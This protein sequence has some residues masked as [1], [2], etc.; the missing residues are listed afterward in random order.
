MRLTKKREEQT[1]NNL[2]C[3]F[4]CLFL[5]GLEVRNQVSA[6]LR[7]L[8]PGEAH[9]GA[10]HEL[11]GVLQIHV[12]NLRGPDG[13]AVDVGLRVRVALD[14]AGEAAD[15]AVQ[16][17]ADAVLAALLVG[18]A[19][20]RTTLEDRLAALHVTGGQGLAFLLRGHLRTK[21]KFFFCVGLFLLYC[22][23]MGHIALSVHS[24]SMA[25]KHR[26]TFTK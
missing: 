23:R 5:Q 19:L 20:G 9:L 13:V 8:D 26:N 15:D 18:V 24:Q 3:L 12:Q 4:V 25:K 6:L 22:F 16:V 21:E 11:L 2:A 14:G 10:R 1:K 17:G 7:L